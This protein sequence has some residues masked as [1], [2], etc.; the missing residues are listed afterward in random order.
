MLSAEQIGH[1]RREGFLAVDPFFD[2]AETTALRRAFEELRDAGRFHNV[3]TDDD[4]Q[5]TS[6]TRENL[7]LCPLSWHH[8]IFA[9]LPFHPKVREAVNGLCG[10]PM[11]KMLDQIFFK[12]ARRGAGTSWHQDNYYFQVP[13]PFAGTAM[14]VA[15]HDATIANGTLRVIPRAFDR[16]LEHGRDPASNHHSRC[17]PDESKAVPIELKAGGVIFFCFNTPH[18]TGGNQTDS[19]RTGLAYHFLGVEDA[20]VMD[21][22]LGIVQ[23]GFPLYG[24]CGK[25]HGPILG[26]EG[27]SRGMREYGR[28]M[29]AALAAEVARLS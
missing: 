8:E 24:P 21:S 27:Y 3:A 6:A 2:A 10:R 20:R 25:E 15:L 5:T 12:P 9:A 7:Q 18:A 23:Q 22:Q 14:W 1:F 11:Y 4:G 29:E 13:D 19:E 26:G 16:I 17:W 28:D